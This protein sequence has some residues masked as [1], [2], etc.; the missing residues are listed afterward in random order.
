MGMFA[1]PL[2]TELKD[3][4]ELVGICDINPHRAQLMSEGCGGG[5][6]VFTDFDEMISNCKPD[7][8][9]VTTI[10]S[11][12]HEFIIRALEAGCDAISEKPM[13]TDAEKCKEI[14]ETE[15]RTGKKV[16]VTFNCRYIPYVVHIK[17][18]LARGTIGKIYSVHMEWF[19]DR[20][21]G[22]D[23]FRRWHRQMENSGGLLVHKSTHHF[24]MVNWW[25]DDEPQSLFAY[26][27]LRHY[28][29][30]RKERG[31]RCLTCSYQNSCE[32]YFDMSKHEVI[33]NMY[34][35]GEKYDGYIR[36][37]CVF[38][39]DIDIYDVMSV[40]VRYKQGA[41]LSYSLTGY[42]PHEGWKASIT[43]SEGRIVAEEYWNGPHYNENFSEVRIY[44]NENK[45]TT[46]QVPKIKGGH[47]G[48]DQRLRRM[49]FVGDLPDP[50]QQQAGS[51]AGAMSMMIG[52]GA[53]L[54]IA[55]QQPI[56][57]QDL[58]NN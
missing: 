7:A 32:F 6:P 11:F 29:P 48:G 40:N 10:D 39:D 54:S 55:K 41:F 26:G 34:Q 28:G 12:H 56:V 24:D 15:Q 20:K 46:I 21:H 53:N 22:A 45:M 51:W 1:R 37:K 3:Y 42:N 57:I 4:A 9:I 31:E 30:N 58:L 50:L 19:L 23:Y 13:T 43:G 36:D 25:L 47:G 27:D 17:E 38:G 8:V 2:V 35:A 5:I 14:L 18:L 16:A 33:Q 44:D 52:A 49:I